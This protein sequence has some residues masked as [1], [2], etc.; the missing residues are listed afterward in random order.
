MSDIYTW[1]C[2][3]VPVALGLVAG[4]AAVAALARRSGQAPIERGSRCPKCG[5]TGIVTTTHGEQWPCLNT[6]Y[7]HHG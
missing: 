2:F 1:T 6:D 7:P 4:L 5:G 3:L